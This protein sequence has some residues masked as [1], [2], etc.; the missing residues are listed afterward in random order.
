M[1]SHLDYSK[2]LSQQPLEVLEKIFSFMSLDQLKKL[3]QDRSIREKMNF[4]SLGFSEIF[5]HITGNEE[6]RIIQKFTSTL[7]TMGTGMY[8]YNSNIKRCLIKYVAK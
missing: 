4:D 7:R 3:G 5:L 2:Y 8:F 6:K 1:N